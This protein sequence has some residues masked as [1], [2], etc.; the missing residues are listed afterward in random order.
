MHAQHD[1]GDFEV[2]NVVSEENKVHSYAQV[3]LD[4][5][6]FAYDYEDDLQLSKL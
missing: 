3:W 2:I 5:C 4:T 1:M 6:W